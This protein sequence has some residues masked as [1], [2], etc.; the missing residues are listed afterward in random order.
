M[1]PPPIPQLVWGRT[2]EVGGRGSTFF[3][4]GSYFPSLSWRWHLSARHAA[5]IHVGQLS[6][7]HGSR[8]AGHLE[9]PGL[10]ITPGNK[11]HSGF[12][13]SCSL[14]LFQNN[15]NR[16]VRGIALFSLTPPL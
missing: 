14:R 10:E 16:N 15:E 5:Q 2:L 1:H 4:V 11:F 9:E 13:G 8:H 7:E 6:W 3:R 12:L